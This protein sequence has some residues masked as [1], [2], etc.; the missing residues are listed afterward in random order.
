MQPAKC[1]G[2][3]HV[4]P[5]QRVSSG[6]HALGRKRRDNGA[7]YRC[8]QTWQAGGKEVRQEAERSMALG[9]VPPSDTQSLRRCARITA[10]ASKGAAARRMQWAGKQPNITPFLICDV[11]LDARLRSQRDLQCHPLTRRRTSTR[12]RALCGVLCQNVIG[13]NEGIE[14]PL[15]I[16]LNSR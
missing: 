1:A 5:A 4:E 16:K 13:V 10:V 2:Q 12:P 14:V 6:L 8:E 15:Q 7:F 3:G 11:L 9:T